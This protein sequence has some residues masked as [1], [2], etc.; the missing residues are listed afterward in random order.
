[1][2]GFHFRPKDRLIG[3]MIPFFWRGEYHL[4]YLPRAPEARHCW[5]HLVSQNLLEW[6]EL[7]DAIA[8]SDEPNKPDAVGCWTGS[9]IEHS[10][11][12]HCFYTG[13]NPQSR[14][15][16]TICHAVS[17]D[18]I[19]WRK[20]EANPILVPDERWYEPQDWRDP[21]VFFNPEAGEFWILICARD[22]RVA[23]ERR[24]CIALATSKD[25]QNWKI[26]EPLW[27]GSVCWAAECPDMF[28]LDN[29]WYLV[30]S[31]GVTRYRWSE[32]FGEVWH[33]FFPDTFDTEF[34]AAAK[35]LF[36]GKRQILFGWVGTLEGDSDFGARQ[37][38]GHMALP[39]EL[40]PQP[41]GSLAVKLPEE[42]ESWQAENANSLQFRSCEPLCGS[43][44]LENDAATANSPNGVSVLR[45]DVPADFFLSVTAI[46]KGETVEFGFLLRMG[47]GKGHKIVIDKNR[48]ALM[49]W[50]SWGDVEPKL[51]RPINWRDCEPLKIHLIVHGSIVEVFVG[52]KVSLAGRIYEPKRGWLGI[53]VANGEVELRSA[54]ISPLPQLY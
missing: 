48:V 6:Q 22:K 27:S 9:V 39:R 11:V 51:S 31:H 33:A 35:T 8:P 53:H 46:P 17:D 3:D 28:K 45:C 54:K 24:G 13:F 29:R 30:Y 10:G 52:D 47:N 50:S 19:H 49:R 42:F 37:W 12:F 34:V 21:F 15:P 43:W 20:D 7:P 2:N 23:F 25:L 26:H 32:K 36:D 44:Q 5:G 41:D 38:G 40:V 18:L 1:M 4:F 16:Q 14:Y